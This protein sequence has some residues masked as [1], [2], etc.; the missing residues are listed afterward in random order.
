MSHDP[1]PGR[2]RKEEDS[3]EDLVQTLRDEYWS[4]LEKERDQRPREVLLHVG[5]RLGDQRYV[6]PIEQVIEVTLIPKISRLP[7][8]PSH[9]AGVINLRGRIIPIIDVRPLL[10]IPEKKKTKDFRIVITRGDGPEL[11]IIVERVDGIVEAEPDDIRLRPEAD[12]SARDPYLSGQIETH[13]G[14]TIIVDA[15]RLIEEETARLREGG[16]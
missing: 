6:L 4:S 11:G 3:I 13:D 9:L 14:I 2:A 5:F 15:A 10:K 16:A 7:R 8:S 1:M 12:R